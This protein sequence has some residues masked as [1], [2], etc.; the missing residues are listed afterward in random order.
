MA[1]AINVSALTLNPEEARSFSEFLV[2]AVLKDPS[3][4]ALH[5]V[6][7]GIKMKS[8]IVLAGQLGKTGLKKDSCTRQTSGE[9]ASLTQK[10][11]EPVGIEDTLIH[12]QDDVNGLFKAYYGQISEYREM[13]EIEGSD[14]EV[15]LAVLLAE[16]ALKTLW[17]AVWYGNKDVAASGEAT[18]GLADAAN[19]KFYDYIDGIWQQVFDAVTAGDVARITITENAEA[20]KADQLDL[21]TNAAKNYLNAMW[22]KADPRLRADETA[23]F[24]VTGELF[25]NLLDSYEAVNS[26]YAMTV[27]ENGMSRITYRGKEVI[28]IETIDIVPREDFEATNAGLAYY[29]PN[30]ALFTTPANI[31]VGTLNESDFDNIEAF[32]DRVTRQH[33][34][35]YGYSVDAKLL[36]GHLAVAAY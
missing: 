35:A 26:N 3:L 9:S 2:E 8:Q 25:Q 17:R 22:K 23:K 14:E 15:F 29:L 30:R 11:W 33:Y 19:V 32:Y 27:L 6:E 21:P 13:Y 16:A 12:C 28:N 24:Y 5:S 10:Y 7:T 18:A 1:T 31:P 34:A 4:R 36:F 20:A